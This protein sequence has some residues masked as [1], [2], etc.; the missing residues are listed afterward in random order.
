MEP[1]VSNEPNL[2]VFK[3]NVTFEFNYCEN[4]PVSREKLCIFKIRNTSPVS[5]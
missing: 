4:A 3:I 5:N 2:K 1:E